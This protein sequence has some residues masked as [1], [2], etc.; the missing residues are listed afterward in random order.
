MTLLDD[1][2]PAASG[3]TSPL[4]PPPRLPDLEDAKRFYLSGYGSSATWIGAGGMAWGGGRWWGSEDVMRPPI[5]YG[6]QQVSGGLDRLAYVLV[7]ELT[8][9]QGLR[10]GWDGRNARQITPQAVDATVWVLSALLDGDSEPPQF[11]PL[12]SGGIQIEWYGRNEVEIAIDASGEAHVLASAASGDVIAEGILDP[13]GP[14]DLV[15][16]T[17]LLVK[18]LSADIAAERRW[19]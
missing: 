13:R 7:Q 19:S 10:R 1:R 17:A 16:T 12:T 9:L 8:R 18:D 4:E 5:Y 15:A 2:R 14:S 11:F 6:Y 3:T